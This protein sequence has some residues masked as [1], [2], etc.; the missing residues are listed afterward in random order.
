MSSNKHCLPMKPV[1]AKTIDYD[2]YGHPITDGTIIRVREVFDNGRITALEAICQVKVVDGELKCFGQYTGDL[3]EF[4]TR[5]KPI[6]E[7]MSAQHFIRQ[8]V[9]G[10]CCEVII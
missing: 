2:S 1:K 3:Y 8:I 6:N 9:A 10:N 5:R 4:A 7:Y